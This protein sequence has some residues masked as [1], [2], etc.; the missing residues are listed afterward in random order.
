[1]KIAVFST[2]AFERPAFDE[3]NVNFHHEFVYHKERLHGTTAIMASGCPG[4]CAFG[5]DR[6]D[7]PTLAALA[8]GGTQV[9][10]LR[11]AGFDSVDLDEA[12]KRNLVVMRVPAY[13]PEAIAEHATALMLTLDRNIHRAYNR[14]RDGNFDLNGLVGFNMCGKT[15]G[16]IG[17][18][19]I[20][21]ALARIMQGFGCNVL[22]YDVV[23][24]PAWEGLGLPYIERSA[25]LAQ[26]DI[27]S[28]HCPLTPETKHLI[29]AAALSSMKRGA[30][31]I[32]A[33]RGAVV[34]T[35]AVVDALKS[36]RLGHFGM[37]VYEGEGPLFDADLSS[38]VIT[39]DVFER[40]TT[41]PNVVIT[42]HQAWLTREAVAQIA[43]TTVSNARDFE[44]GKTRPEN[45]VGLG[46]LKCAV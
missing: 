14:V 45:V 25:L 9:I 40:L 39:D 42:A 11:M 2:H 36:G 33:S 27:V 16:I 4:V 1:M 7:A 13:A 24:N 6:L 35:H 12:A 28:L 31:L 29:D 34:D 21:L 30:M 44:M 22:G 23:H 38:T 15:V 10:L 20:G 46:N 19:K 37:D 26:S 43:L 3:A 5:N 17:T 41:F 18:G 8:A 32:N